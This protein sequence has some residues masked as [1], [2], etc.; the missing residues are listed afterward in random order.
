M[1]LRIVEG[2]RLPE[3]GY[4]SL[5]IGGE[6]EGF[7]IPAEERGGARHAGLQ[8]RIEEA[9][10]R[11]RIA[12]DQEVLRDRHPLL[13][14]ERRL[15]LGEECRGRADL[16]LAQVGAA[17]AQAQGGRILRPDLGIDH[18]GPG[19]VALPG[20]D[21]RLDGRDLRLGGGAVKP[22]VVVGVDESA[23]QGKQ[24]DQNERHLQKGTALRDR[25]R[26]SGVGTVFRGLRDTL[27]GLQEPILSGPKRPSRLVAERCRSG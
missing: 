7:A 11:E 4:G 2:E 18:E 27:L 6:G 15:D 9:G 20:N 13:L 8:R 16:A 24:D 23:D 1:N 19:L 17:D 3:G 10:G 26:R 22:P 14:D 21:E 5:R 25:R 12:R